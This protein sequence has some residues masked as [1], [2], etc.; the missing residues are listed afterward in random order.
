MTTWVLLRG[1]MRESRH[2]GEFPDLFK[3][4]L[5]AQNVVTLDLPGNGRLHAQ[6]SA[7]SVAEMAHYCHAQLR[8]LD[9]APPYSLLALSL[10]GMVAVSWSELYPAE[11][12]RMVLINTSMAPYNPFYQ[13]L[14]PANYSALLRHL[15]FGSADQREDLILRVT[16]RLKSH[17]DQRQAILKQWTAYAREHPIALANILRQLCAAAGY[18]VSPAAPSVPMLLLAS[19]QDELVDAKCSLTLAQRWHC[20]NDQYKMWMP[21]YAY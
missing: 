14:R 13:R 10:G 18:R 2:W 19:R 6:T 17:S 15:L 21:D 3:Y 1:L 16:S 5:D 11:L 4:T 7:T 8:Q 20:D 9:C 12:E